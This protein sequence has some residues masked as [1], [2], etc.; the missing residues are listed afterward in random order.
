MHFLSDMAA[1][2]ALHFE[3]ES[4]GQHTLVTG[5]ILLTNYS[6]MA[7]YDVYI[8]KWL[9]GDNSNKKNTL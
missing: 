2:N 4:M 5:K 3:H 1:V 6:G 7:K 9:K 8:F